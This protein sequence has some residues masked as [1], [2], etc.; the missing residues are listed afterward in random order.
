[1]QAILQEKLQNTPVALKSYATPLYQLKGDAKIGRLQE[2]RGIDI[3]KN[4]IERNK[5]E[6]EK[7]KGVIVQLIYKSGT[8]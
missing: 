1:L 3:S 7:E 8:S 4:I 5:R 2:T 6:R